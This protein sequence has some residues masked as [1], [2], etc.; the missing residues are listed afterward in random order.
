MIR[1][2][3]Q[4]KWFRF[5]LLGGLT[6]LVATMVKFLGAIPSLFEEKMD[7]A[8][9]LELPLFVFGAGF[10]CGVLTWGLMGLSAVFG[11]MGDALIGAVV[12]NAFFLMCSLMFDAGLH[13]GIF[14]FATCLGLFAGWLFG[15]DFRRE[16]WAKEFNAD[17]F[18]PKEKSDFDQDE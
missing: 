15:R 13:G 2:V 7:W 3:L 16:Q 10:A 12:M 11:A 6:M 8:G 1:S 17:E 5:G 18:N 14:L 4:I 9:L